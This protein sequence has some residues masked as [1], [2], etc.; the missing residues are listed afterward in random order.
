MIEEQESTDEANI[1]DLHVSVQ[2]KSKR[3]AL[4]LSQNDLARVANVSVQ[5]IQKY[6]NGKNRITCGRL[7]IFAKLLC[8][9][10]D[11]FFN[12]Y[13]SAEKAKNRE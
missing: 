1:V 10:I 13:I 2:L 11:F 12:N 5:Q 4:G 8:V 3:I 7:Y 9:P 6:E